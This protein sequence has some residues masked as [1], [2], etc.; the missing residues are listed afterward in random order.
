MKYRNFCGNNVSLLGMGCMRLPMNDE[1]VDSDRAMEI[2]DKCIE[3]GIN[4]FDTAHVY[5][6]GSNESFVG[7]IVQKYDRDKIF[8]ATKLPLFTYTKKDSFMNLLDEQL[9][10]MKTDYVDYYLFHALNKDKFSN[11]QFEEYKDFVKEVKDLGKVK[12]IGF[13]FHDDYDTFVKIIDDFKWEFCQLQF[14]YVDA[15]DQ[16]AL[17]M[18]EYAKSKGVEVVIME[19]LRG[20]RLTHVPKAVRNILDEKFAGLS[21]AEVS[22]KYIADFDNNKVI[23]S[24]MRSVEDVERNCETFSKYDANTLTEE[25]KECYHN[26]EELFRSY[27]IINCTRCDYCKEGC[28]MGIP[29][30]KIFERYNHQ[31]ENPYLNE[32]EVKE[33]YNGL[34]TDATACID[35]KACER[36]CP[37]HLA[38]VTL[39]NKCNEYFRD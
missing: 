23:L 30:S 4:Y 31:L 35:C 14:N 29:I 12:H 26:A 24:G 36:A 39:L 38:I 16:D 1:L 27:N 17:K 20:G 5:S 11:M 21:D 9:E 10:N 19:P 25:E 2:I 18:Y 13:S 22:F 7:E 15:Y 34:E 37:Q 33:W 32:D 8:L 3:K 6:N 28:P